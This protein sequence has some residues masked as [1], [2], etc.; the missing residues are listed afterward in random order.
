MT[1]RPERCR[2][3]SMILGFASLIVV[4]WVLSATSAGATGAYHSINAPASTPSPSLTPMTTPTPCVGRWEVVASPNRGQHNMFYDMQFAGSNDGWV[5]GDYSPVTGGPTRTLAQHWDGS[6][7]STILSPNPSSAWNQL[8]GISILS[9][10]DIWAT[11]TTSV[12]A[13]RNELV[14]HWDGQAWTQSSTPGTQSNTSEL[15]DIVAIAANDVWA[16]GYYYISGYRPYALHWNGTTWT[17]HDMPMVGGRFHFLQSV[18]AL[19]P[20]NV[21]AVGYTSSGFQGAQLSTLIE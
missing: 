9:S 8:R 21:W 6:A 11:G 14:L 12:S 2:T 20:D 4:M 7:W 17:H 16:I 13:S 18:V 3:W 19:S 15:T 10:N 1:S 5:V